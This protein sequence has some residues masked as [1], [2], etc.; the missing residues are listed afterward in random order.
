MNLKLLKA[1][2][3]LVGID[4]KTFAKLQNWSMSTCYRKLSGKAFF[5]GI[6]I[7]TCIDILK[8]RPTDIT[9]IFFQTIC[10]IRQRIK[11]LK[12]IETNGK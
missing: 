12:E 10:R 1:H 11:K 2:M 6:E 3:I 8:L 5:T 4:S 9:D 7:G